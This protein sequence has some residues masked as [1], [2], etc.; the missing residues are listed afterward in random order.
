MENSKSLRSYRVGPGAFFRRHFPFL[1]NPMST[2]Y[3]GIFVIVLSMLWMAYALAN[4]E[5]TQLLNWDYT[6][7]FVPFAYGY[8]DSW[9]TFFRT[10][11]FPM[12]DPLLFMGSDNIGSG[13]Y[14]GLFDP[15]VVA[16][17]I[18][19]RSFIPQGYAIMT[20]LRFAVSALLMRG[21]LKYI[22]AKEWT[23]RIGAI[24]YAFSGFAT[25][26]SGFPNVLTA[27]VYIP[28]ILWGIEKAI[29]ERKIGILVWGL[30][31]EGITS[32]F[33]LV[34]V[35]I[36]GV[37]YAL[38][39]YFWTIKRRSKGEN[40]W[41]LGYGIMAFAL[42]LMLCAFTWIPSVRASALSG[43]A[44]SIGSAYLKAIM[45][46][47]KQHNIP[48]FFSQVFE[49]VG[50]HPAR[51][52]MGL[53]SFFFPT[54]GFT[55][56][57]L[58]SS[59]YD[60]WTAALFCYTPILICFIMALLHSLRLKKW[61]HI[62]AV[63]ICCYLVFTNLAYFMFYAF[64]GN[65]YGRWYIIL[66]PVIIAYAC[67]GFD[68]RFEGPKF[69]PFA[70]SVMAMVGS[71]I[72]YYVCDNVLK[73]VTFSS[74]IYNVHGTTYWQSEYKTASE[75]YD[76][77]F[78]AWF[79]YYQLA[80]IFIEG[81]LLC[82][83]YRK[84][85]IEKALFGCLAVEVVMMGN[86]TYAFNGIWSLRNSFGGG[87]GEVTV[88]RQMTDAITK[89]DKSFFRVHNELERGSSYISYL[90]GYNAVIS[91]HSLMNFEV[92][93]F[94]LANQFK[95]T[96]S[97]E[98]TYGDTE[99][100]NPSWSGAYRYK[101]FI[102]DTVLG[103]RYYMVEN[104]YS[105]FTDGQGHHYFFEPNVPFG[106]VEI[107]TDLERNYYR[108][109]KT[110]T[111]RLMELGYAVDS[112]RLY[113]MGHNP[114][115]RP[116]IS[117]FYHNNSYLGAFRE[118]QRMQEVEL[119][120]AV[121]EDGVELPG[122]TV[123]TEVPECNTDA[124]LQENYGLRRYYRTSGFQTTYYETGLNDGDNMLPANGTDYQAEGLS[125]FLKNSVKQEDVSAT[126]TMKRDKGKL[127]LHNGGAYLNADAEGA[128]FDLHFYTNS[129]DSGP[130]VYAIG[131]KFDE[132]GVRTESNV[133]LGFDNSFIDNATRSSYWQSQMSTFGFYARGRVR[134][135]VFCYPG[136]GEM[137]V[138]PSEVY[139]VKREK[140]EIDAIYDMLQENKLLDVETDINAFR[141]KTQYKEDRIVTTSLGF[142]K[143]WSCVATS[144]S[145]EKQNLKMLKLNGG[146]VGFVA[147]G[148]VDESGTPLTYTYILSYMTPF[149]KGSV[150]LWCVGILG[151]FGAAAI[152][153][154]LGRKKKTKDEALA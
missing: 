101:R 100:Y 48:E 63:L 32:F 150:A 78:A 49:E 77:I 119:Y 56:L 27:T 75:P 64:S 15:F 11:Q 97:N 86:L 112:S 95:N 53:V 65:G 122:F 33:Y 19:P 4:N 43:R 12:Y 132:N 144:P 153:W 124:L 80:F 45:D 73:G 105:G 16:L 90:A 69:I 106:A 126:F 50:D 18:F 103:Y 70:A 40:L 91:F 35:C 94:A 14:Y 102:T 47:L 83:G 8:Y 140:Y 137:S 68:Q 34:V 121:I 81:T 134:Y 74:S 38:W 29:K 152:P 3:F 67:W 154:F 143:G 6:W 149:A 104:R 10:G 116:Y 54:G 96:G 133:C 60:A 146:L 141:F 88:S 72:V 89:Q 148:G 127:V 22:G 138:S 41:V 99:I 58:E 13:S 26:M 25:F 117:N 30:F 55:R 71:L 114:D 52:M 7:Q 147:P 84:K 2:F 66:V 135:L 92:D 62:I 42:G 36:W 129:K 21:Y 151:V 130:R 1:F 44:S 128:Y 113:Y 61:S 115:N 136:D 31:L 107:P 57:P 46:S 59:G 20:F 120:G 125:Y 109:Y 93:D 123:K 118:M 76:N 24:A 98:K 139:Y 28:M 85:W 37:F 82:I 110:P 17:V 23:A 87:V 9:H 5:F 51:E 79:L 131:D 39:R 145:G 108:V 111:D 142:D